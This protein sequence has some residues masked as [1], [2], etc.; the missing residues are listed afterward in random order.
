MIEIKFKFCCADCP[1]RETYI[2]EDSLYSGIT[3]EIT[4]TVIGCK[5]EKVCKAY[6]EDETPI[7]NSIKPV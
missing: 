6:I 3:K 2:N 4:V 7:Q 1:N 5:H